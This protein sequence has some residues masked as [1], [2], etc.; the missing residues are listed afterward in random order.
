M[1]ANPLLS[2]IITTKNEEDV[3]E[4][5]LESV[6]SQTYKKWE[7]ILVDNNSVDKTCKIAREYTKHVYRKGPE[8]S[9]QRNYGVAKSSGEYVVILDADHQLAPTTLEECVREFKKESGVGALVLPEKSFGRGFWTKFKVFEREFYVGEE[10]IEA[11]RVFRKDLFNKFGGYDLSI[12]GPEDWD[13]P[14]RMR[15]AGVKIGRTKS[16]ILHNERIF[17]PWKSA[18]KKFYYASGASVY[19]KRHP[20][21]LASHGN[22]L[23]RSVFFKK[24]KKLVT[25]PLL[26]AGMLFVRA[27]EMGGAGLGFLYGL[28]FK[29]KIGKLFNYMSAFCGFFGY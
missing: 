25:H 11:A 9:A 21:K 6:K 10:N 16:F 23:F 24:W 15:K 26:S 18:K 20:E 28:A 29:R 27:L 2:V 1:K 14:L 4:D 3:I 8:R 17:N 7:I 19:W 22:L 5:L 13:L 12:T